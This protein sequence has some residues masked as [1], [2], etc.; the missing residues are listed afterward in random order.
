MT[1]PIVITQAGPVILLDVPANQPDTVDPGPE[2]SAYSVLELIDL[3]DAV[4]N[5]LP[6]LMLLSA[7]THFVRFH[8]R[9]EHDTRSQ[10]VEQGM[11]A[12]EAMLQRLNV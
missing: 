8:T 3:R 4:A 10:Q 1:D 2:P 5:A 11:A 12:L 6:G 7:N 9:G